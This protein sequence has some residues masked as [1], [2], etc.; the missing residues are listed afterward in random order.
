MHKISNWSSK[1]TLWFA[2]FYH[3]SFITQFSGEKMFWTASVYTACKHGNGSQSKWKEIST[4]FPKIHFKTYHTR[5]KWFGDG[6]SFL[7]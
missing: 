2:N 5:R 7:I 1:Y 6:K 3:P 4:A